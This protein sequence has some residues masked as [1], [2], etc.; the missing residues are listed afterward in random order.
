MEGRIHVFLFGISKIDGGSN[1][2]ISIYNIAYSHKREN[3]F[4]IVKNL[5]RILYR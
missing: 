2:W 1:E 4:I 5:H 3:Y